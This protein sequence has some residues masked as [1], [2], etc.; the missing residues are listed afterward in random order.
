MTNKIYFLMESFAGMGDLMCQKNFI[1]NLFKNV[2]QQY[3]LIL[4]SVVPRTYDFAISLFSDMDNVIVTQEQYASITEK[5]KFD[6]CIKIHYG[7][8]FDKVNFSSIKDKV[9]MTKLLNLYKA[10]KN[11]ENRNIPQYAATLLNFERAKKWGNNFYTVYNYN[12]LNIIQD[13]HVNIPLIQQYENTLK[14]LPFYHEKYITIT[15]D[16]GEYIN[17]TH[18][19]LWP[20][21]KWE[22]LLSMIKDRYPFVKIVQVEATEN[23]KINT[24]ID[25]NLLGKHIEYAKHVLNKSILHIST[26]GGMVHLASQL[27]TKCAV[28]FGQSPIHF[29]GYKNNI[30]IQVG[31]CQGCMNLS[32]H[33]A[34]CAKNMK[35]PTCM[36]SITPEI[37]MNNI[38]KYLD[39]KLEVTTDDKI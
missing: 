13:Q 9:L 28:L 12:N 18:A 5:N 14:M 29:Y 11:Y 1:I 16:C 10:S 24:N 17:G 31:E 2:D 33:I 39:E 34:L 7:I 26:E 8:I 3:D 27:N 20:L 19:K 4:S 22:K 21:E 30:N 23:N 38:I 37:V 25:Y 36:Y 6:F 15:T 35:K 32:K